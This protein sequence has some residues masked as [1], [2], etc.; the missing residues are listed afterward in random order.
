M[1]SCVYLTRRLTW[2][3]ASCIRFAAER[4]YRRSAF[5]RHR[6]PVAV[7]SGCTWRPCCLVFF[8]FTPYSYDNHSVAHW[9]L[10]VHN[11]GVIH[12]TLN[13]IHDCSATRIDANAGQYRIDVPIFLCMKNRS[14]S[15]LDL[16]KQIL[17]GGRGRLGYFADQL[18]LSRSYIAR[19]YQRVHS[20]N[21]SKY[22]PD[23]CASR[24][25]LLSA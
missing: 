13:R 11:L 2:C 17:K 18:E 8:L 1:D 23:T 6:S 15:Y 20:T 5:C 9:P 14:V 16:E 3:F 10:L 7:V 4:S 12:G 21:T 25:V 19:V 24:N 22:Q